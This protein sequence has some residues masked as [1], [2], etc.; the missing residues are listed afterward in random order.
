METKNKA[1]KAAANKEPANKHAQAP[2]Y[3]RETLTT[4]NKQGTIA[5]PT[6]EPVQKKPAT[7]LGVKAVNSLTMTHRQ[8]N[9]NKDADDSDMKRKVKFKTNL[10]IVHRQELNKVKLRT[11]YD[12]HRKERALNNMLPGTI[13]NKHHNQQKPKRKMFKRKMSK[14]VSGSNY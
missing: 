1:H 10:N 4:K 2:N 3:A 8:T 12:I 9:N 7:K 11:E 6:V 5:G 14:F 13:T